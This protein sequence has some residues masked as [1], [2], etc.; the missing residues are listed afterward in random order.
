MSDSVKHECGI[1]L[2]RHSFI[3]HNGLMEWSINGKT[4]HGE[5]Q[6]MWPVHDWSQYRRETGRAG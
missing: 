2:I 4:G 5:D 1:T 6:D 3:D